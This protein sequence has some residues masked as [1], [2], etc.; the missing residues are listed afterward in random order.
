VEIPNFTY[1]R[2]TAIAVFTLSRIR[3]APGKGRNK[4]RGMKEKREK[5]NE[6]RLRRN[7]RAEDDAAEEK[8]EKEEKEEKE[9]NNTGSDEADI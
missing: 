4:V 9:E 1:L 6:G 7:R 2:G 8:K 3:A 5:T